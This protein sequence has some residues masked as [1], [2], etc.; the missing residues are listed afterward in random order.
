[1]PEPEFLTIGLRACIYIATIAVA[2]SQ[3]V[4]WTLPRLENGALQ[5]QTR[6]GMA[7]L[8]IVEPLHI[9]LFQL[10][11][12]DGDAGLAVSPA[13]LVMGIDMPGNQ[14]SAVRIAS[15]ILVL[16]FFNRV[17]WIALAAGLAMIG[18][19]ALEG[20]TASEGNRALYA[21][22]LILHV[23]L[24]HW[25]LAALYP[26]AM[27][28]RGEDTPAFRAFIDNFSRS[29]ILAV[30]VLILAGGLLLGLLTDWR[31]DIYN[32]YQFRFVAKIGLVALI[33][34]IAARNKFLI[35]PRLNSEPG[36]GTRLMRRSIFVEML[37]GLAILAAT[38]WI[39]RTG[40]D[41]AHD[42]AALSNQLPSSR[43]I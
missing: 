10:A 38:A 37:V 16:V 5:R 3:L 4:Q 26:L 40:P 22:L 17:R 2:G 8:L 9:A 15:A 35:T 25:W 18:S 42:Q 1:M 32:A 21:G 29:A 23:L 6:F 14:A 30:P 41:Y 12:A 39:L 19:Y 27:Q 31:V 7:L 33:L 24:V 34:A 43:S 13:F 28:A 36:Q 20:H 11:I